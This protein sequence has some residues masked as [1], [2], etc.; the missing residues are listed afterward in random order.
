MREL[1]LRNLLSLAESHIHG[2][3]LVRA[4]RIYS[5]VIEIAQTGEFEHEFAHARLGDLKVGL[6]EFD[7]ALPHLRKIR[8]LNSDEPLYALMLGRVLLELG[9]FQEAGF[10]LMDAVSSAFYASEALME[11]MRVALAMG[12]SDTADR[13]MR[14]ARKLDSTI[15]PSTN[16]TVDLPKS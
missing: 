4:A 12:E 6:G 8:D 10:H 1:R 15:S 9:K 16:S 5:R 3:R 2:G 11:L 13:L 14:Q 7:A